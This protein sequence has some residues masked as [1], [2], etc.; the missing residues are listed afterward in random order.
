MSLCIQYSVN[1]QMCQILKNHL[2]MLHNTPVLDFIQL[3]NKNKCI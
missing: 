1:E 3:L 2:F